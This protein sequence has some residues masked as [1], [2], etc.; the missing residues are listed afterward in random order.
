LN[1]R[2]NKN[3]NY[4]NK[5]NNSRSKSPRVKFDTNQD[6]SINVVS[7]NLKE[8]DTLY[9]ISTCI[10]FLEKKLH[11][12][13]LI[14]SGATNSFINKNVLPI[15][16]QKRIDR[17]I[18]SNGSIQNDDNFAIRNI[19]IETLD[20]TFQA[21]VVEVT[22]EFKIGSYKGSHRFI[23]TDS[24]IKEQAIFGK[25]FITTHNIW[26]CG[27]K[28]Q[29]Y[30]KESLVCKLT[31]EQIIPPNSEVIVQAST[32]NVMRM[33][34]TAVF[35]PIKEFSRDVIIARSVNKLE[36]NH[37]NIL[38]CNNSDKAVKLNS[39][40]IVGEIERCE[41]VFET[42]IIAPKEPIAENCRQVKSMPVRRQINPHLKEQEKG[43]LIELIKKHQSCFSF[44]DLHAAPGLCFVL[45]C[46]T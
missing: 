19:T 25:D 1:S 34:R 10:W 39:N 30:G 26:I 38:I 17:F 33:Y 37:V 13:S 2:Y 12:E 21:T 23:I 31:K 43:K 27:N 9:H 4:T 24:M 14:D 29:I 18:D 7:L 32:S 6:A 45:S 42:K 35:E 22:L 41:E 28:I 20:K 46:L 44:N 11:F 8:A 15:E 36:E 40:S 3:Q 16:L 5:R